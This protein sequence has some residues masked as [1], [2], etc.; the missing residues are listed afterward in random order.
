[1]NAPD[2]LLQALSG[3]GPDG[4]APAPQ[5][6]RLLLVDDDPMLRHMAART[7]RHAGFTVVDTADGTAA[8]AAFAAQAFDLVLLDVMMPGLDGFE[9]CQRLRALP[10]GA[11]VPVIMLTGLDD[12]A[13]IEQAYGH[14]ATD[15]ITKPINWTLLSH[16]VRY[17]L[18]AAESAGTL[19]LGRERLARAQRLAGMGSWAFT[20]DGRLEC[21]P[22]LARLYGADTP[23]QTHWFSTPEAL[24]TRVLPTERDAVAQARRRLLDEGRSYQI[25]YRIERLDGQLRT[26]HEQGMPLQDESGL[27]LGVE[28]I[29]QDIT[30]RVQA[31]QRIRQLAHYDAVTGLPNR[32][33][34]AELA[35]PLLERARRQ[36]L[37]CAVLHIDLDQFKAVNDAFGHGGGDQV[38]QCL[39]ERLRGWIRGS[40]LAAARGPCEPC[41]GTDADGGVVARVGGNAFTLLITDLAGQ[42]PAAAVAQ[43]L[44]KAVG[45]PITLPGVAA[46]PLVLSAGIGI[47]L[48]PGDAP[49]LAGLTRCAEQAAYAAKAR[50]RG[51]LR[52]FD[53]TLDAQ[54]A[55]RLRLE[56]ELRR[57]IAGGELRLHY[58][59]KVLL[60]AQGGAGGRI[61][62]AEAL[63]RWQHPERGLVP[64]GEFIALAEET[65]LIAPLTDWVLAE[66]CRQLQAWQQAGLP[67]PALAVNLSAPSFADPGLDERLTALLA[68]HG[69]APDRLV[70]EVTE[71]LL[72]REPDATAARLAALRARGFGLALDD[73]GTG[74][75]SL[76]YLKRFAIDELKIDRS[77]IVDAA[78]GGRDSALAKAIIALGRDLGLRVV[79]EG[80]ETP[81]QAAFLRG[82]GCLYQQGWLYARSLPADGFA[83]L[84]ADGRPLG[85]A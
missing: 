41:P 19:S 64:P 17:A 20:A 14:G 63:V 4:Q 50:G 26:L 81:E 13:S 33:F 43:R 79:A 75:S 62:G 1:M 15:F 47:A 57:A 53:E 44:L 52:F 77:F 59:P 30:E 22:E 73:F 74:Y 82:H 35:A 72:M 7:L 68:A 38:L 25:E 37:H 69:L 36:G 80:V 51:Q 65:G 39:A 8:L 16:R 58:Q 31:A 2:R 32:Q 45:L 83:A 27:R 11:R 84:L 55:Q 29:T 9:T 67:V 40:D 6:P 56:A 5:P 21:S 54:A 34:F 76:S 71:S 24:L 42:A 28:G 85:P 66:A 70:L 60:D 46:P 61:A 78:Q 48:Y 18:R 23:D 12:T 10:R 3:L 49:D